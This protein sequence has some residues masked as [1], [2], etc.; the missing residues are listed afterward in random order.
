MLGK[1]V[2]IPNHIGIIMDGNRRWA[3][4]K[5]LPVKAGHLEGTK[6]LKR[7]LRYIKDKQIPIK[8]LTVYAFSTE[9]WKRSDEEISNLMEIFLKY[10]NEVI[11]DDE[12]LRVKIVGD[13]TP[14]SEELKARMC[15]MEEKTD[16]N[17]GL[18]LG[19]CLNYSGRSDIIQAVKNIAKKVKNCEINIDD[20]D[21]EMIS[22]NL[23]TY[24]FPYP[25]IVV[26]TS[27]EYRTSDFMSWQIAY[28]ELYFTQKFWPDFN[29]EDLDNVILEYSKRNR[30]FGK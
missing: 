16:K 17:T 23:Y 29:E 11:S 15:E 19:V 25:D 13:K 5:L 30:R 21:Q 24:E 14:F 4:S 28:S 7:V 9:N 18:T 12:G 22:N 20:I 2:I 26:R 6:A 10:I 27:G 3:K 8:Y 1:D